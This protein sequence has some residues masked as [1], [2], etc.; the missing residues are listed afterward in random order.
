VG[1]CGWC[2]FI[3]IVAEQAYEGGVLSGRFF[4]TGPYRNGHRDEAF[5]DLLER[6]RVINPL[7]QPIGQPIEIAKK[8]KI[9]FLKEN[10]TLAATKQTRKLFSVSNSPNFARVNSVP[11]AMDESFL[12]LFFKKEGLS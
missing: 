3:F 11:A 10:E 9:S 4:T 7:G 8:A 2:D 12:P 5:F 1:C 6:P